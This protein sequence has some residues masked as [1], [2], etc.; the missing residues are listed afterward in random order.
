[1]QKERTS[2]TGI[3]ELQALPGQPRL[4]DAILLPEERD[5]VGMLA[6]D[7]PP[8]AAINTW[9]GS[10]GAVYAITTV[11]LWD[12]TALRTMTICR[13]SPR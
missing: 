11:Q 8:T 12:T 1:M 10:T 4:Q 13:E 3:V 7:A 5:D 9:N 2:G 6:V